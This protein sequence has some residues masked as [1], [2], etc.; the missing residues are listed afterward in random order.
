MKTDTNELPQITKVIADRIEELKGV[1][2]QREIAAQ[3]GYVNQNMITMLKLGSAKVALDRVPALASAL[4]VDPAY[5]LRL[6][7]EQFY[8]QAV[9]KQLLAIAGGS[10]TKNETAI[11][12][13]VREASGNTDPKLT[14]EM[15]LAI[16]QLF[17]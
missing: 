5:L 17:S 15:K 8:D 6:A 4:E 12:S 7:M 14:E 2:L 16:A 11:I 10:F 9:V 13:E 1:K 3:A